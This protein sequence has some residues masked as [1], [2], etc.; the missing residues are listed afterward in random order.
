MKRLAWLIFVIAWVPLGCHKQAPA[1]ASA[2][3]SEI[4][5]APDA[6]AAEPIP[7]SSASSLVA[8]PPPPVRPAQPPPPAPAYVMARAEN[9]VRENVVG[10]VNAA[11]TSE[12]QKFVQKTGRLPENFAEFFRADRHAGPVFTCRFVA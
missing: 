2:P 5:S 11:L 1:V 6:A 12:L 4:P 7:P 8:A 3:P 10:E 9:I